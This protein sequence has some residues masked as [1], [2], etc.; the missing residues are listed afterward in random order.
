MQPL[1]L[2]GAFIDPLERGGVQVAAARVI[3]VLGR[4]R[5]KQCG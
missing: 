4:N 1:E 5:E 3:V 2:L